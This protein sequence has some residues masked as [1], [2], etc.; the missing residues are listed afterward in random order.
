M[1]KEWFKKARDESSWNNHEEKGLLK[2]EYIRDYTLRLW[3]EEDPGEVFLPLRDV[4]R[5]RLV[6]GDYSL[7]WLNPDTGIYD[8]NAIDLAPECVR[9]F[10][11][12]YGK[13]LKI[14]EKSLPSKKSTL[15]S[16]SLA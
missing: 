4:E 9:F 12:K 14:P 1:W 8:D 16:E 2:A 7:I 6:K 11:E 10:C 15:K 5:F 13:K 3:F